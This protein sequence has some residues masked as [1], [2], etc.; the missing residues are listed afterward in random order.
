MVASL[1]YTDMYVI[2]IYKVGAQVGARVA[3]W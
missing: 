2:S 3:D 1:L